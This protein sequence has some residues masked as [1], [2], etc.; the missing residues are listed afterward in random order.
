MSSA[1]A[2]T[3]APLH[4]RSRLRL[5]R[6]TDACRAEPERSDET[7]ARRTTLDGRV[8]YVLVA[9]SDASARSRMLGDLRNLLPASTRFLEACET[10]EMLARAASSRMIVLTDDLGAVSTESLVRLLG[11]RHPT[12]P[13]LAVES[14]SRTSA[15]ADGDSASV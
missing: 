14:R 11:R 4:T 2:S 7:Q 9:G 8:A 3:D 10:W 5:V 1:A 6:D 12:L 15:S 13:V